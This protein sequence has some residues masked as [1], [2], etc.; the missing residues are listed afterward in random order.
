MKH[1]L[2]K[3]IEEVGELFEVLLTSLVVTTVDGLWELAEFGFLSA[4]FPT[5]F[6]DLLFVDI[7]CHSCLEMLFCVVAVAA[8]EKGAEKK[9]L[10]VQPAVRPVK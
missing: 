1:K 6:A 4:G 9:D 2:S 3:T 5:L 10:H 7:I 8:Y